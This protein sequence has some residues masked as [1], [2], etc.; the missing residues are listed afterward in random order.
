MLYVKGMMHGGF[1]GPHLR[2]SVNEMT[3]KRADLVRKTSLMIREGWDF[4]LGW[5]WEARK[6]QGYIWRWRAS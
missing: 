3:Q 2:V 6:G 1:L 4:G 5:K